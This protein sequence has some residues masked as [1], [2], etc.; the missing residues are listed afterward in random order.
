MEAAAA[1]HAVEV[2]A[3]GVTLPALLAVPP[4]ARGVVVFAHGSGSGRLSPRNRAVAQVLFEAG[5][6]TL[7]AD[8]LTAD[9][10]AEDAITARLRFDVRLLA[11]R[12]VGGIDWLVAD[13]EI[14]D[15]PPILAELPV[16]CFGASTG[17]RQ[18]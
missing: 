7:L 13:A 11:E 3:G 9:E 5:F 12:V 2:R 16:G 18:R 17:L 8:L 15:L 14:G 4:G 10:E 1:E 6:A